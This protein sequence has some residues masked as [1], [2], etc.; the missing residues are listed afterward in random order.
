MRHQV[1]VSWSDGKSS[2]CPMWR[3]DD[4]ACARQRT[5]STLKNKRVGSAIFPERPPLW[6]TSALLDLRVKRFQALH[7]ES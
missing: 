2:R 6:L 4:N 1:L 5:L 3:A 7:S